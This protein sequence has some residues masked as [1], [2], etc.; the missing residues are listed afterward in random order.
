MNNKENVTEPFAAARGSEKWRAYGVKMSHGEAT[1][2]AATEGRAISP[3][4]DAVAVIGEARP[5]TSP[6]DSSSATGREE[7][8]N[9]KTETTEQTHNAPASS[10]ERVVSR[11]ELAILANGG[12]DYDEKG[13]QCEPDVNQAPCR[14]C[15][16]RDALNETLRYLRE[17]AANTVLCRTQAKTSDA[18]EVDA[19]A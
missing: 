16:I 18:N 15:A 4:M 13:C 1:T 9:M 14:Y 2:L 6:N 11:V 3:A 19:E 17:Q 7:P 10:L 5:A 8:K 12:G